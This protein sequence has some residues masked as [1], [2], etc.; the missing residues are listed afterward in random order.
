ML[1]AEN[2]ESAFKFDKVVYRKL[3]SFSAHGVYYI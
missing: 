3:D 2:Y 1:H